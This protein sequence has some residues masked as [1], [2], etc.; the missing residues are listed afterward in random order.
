MYHH[1]GIT[2]GA[3]GDPMNTRH[4]ANIVLMDSQAQQCCTE[5]H[6]KF[7]KRWASNTDVGPTL[8]QPYERHVV[9]KQ[10]RDVHPKLFQCCLRRWPN[11]EPALGERFVFAGRP[12]RL[13]SRKRDR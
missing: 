6:A 4:S 1:L 13:I 3:L 2:F 12:S 5:Q 7:N 11:I 8:N 10:T 9:S